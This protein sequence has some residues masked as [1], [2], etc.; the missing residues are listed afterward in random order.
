[1]EA[2]RIA[3]IVEAK[4]W[5][6][7]PWHHQAHVK[8]AG[9]DCVWLL[10][11]VFQHIG[12]LPED[13]DPGNYSREWYFHKAEEKYMMGVEQ[14]AKRLPEGQPPQPADVALYK[15]GKC[16]SHGGIVLDDKLLIHAN[17][18]NKRVEVAMLRDAN[19]APYLHSFWT[20][21]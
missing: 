3:A 7:T 15:I 18:R 14:Y 20:P 8:G 16:V 4:T 12:K 9:V 13:Y 1:M 11:K 17:R 19:L 6:G 10:I 21:F 2:Q 5:I